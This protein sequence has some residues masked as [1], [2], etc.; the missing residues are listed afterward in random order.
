M[1][2]AIPSSVVWFLQ[3]RKNHNTLSWNT[4]PN[5]I[6][7]VLFGDM[8]IEV[9]LCSANSKDIFK[10]SIL[11]FAASFGHCYKNK[12]TAENWELSSFSWLV[13]LCWYSNRLDTYKSN[14]H[15]WTRSKK[16]GLIINIIFLI[17]SISL[18]YLKI[19]CLVILFLVLDFSSKKN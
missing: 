19:L 3:S 17:I 16:M 8:Y 5:L 11:L 14:I 15:T 7:Y 9:D 13:Y 12:C 1:V 18:E 4:N 10:M 6:I 2:L